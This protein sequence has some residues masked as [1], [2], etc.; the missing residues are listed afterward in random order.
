MIMVTKLRT[1]LMIPKA[2]ANFVSIETKVVS[3]HVISV[4]ISMTSHVIFDRNTY[5]FPMWWEVSR[6]SE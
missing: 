4:K 5:T 2:I 1:M 3:T 6:D